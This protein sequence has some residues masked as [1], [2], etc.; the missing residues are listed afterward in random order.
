[1]NRIN[2]MLYIIFLILAIIFAWTKL[3]KI[4]Y[5][6]IYEPFVIKTIETNCDCKE[7]RQ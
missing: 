3:P 1:M 4:V 7:R 5:K 6:I 2:K